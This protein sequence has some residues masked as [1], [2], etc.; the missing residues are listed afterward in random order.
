MVEVAEQYA[1]EL[2]NRELVSSTLALRMSKFFGQTSS[3][4]SRRFSG[5]ARCKIPRGVGRYQTLTGV[6]V[7]A[8]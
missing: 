1:R 2:L 4:K 5:E 8:A 7:A 3:P 6:A